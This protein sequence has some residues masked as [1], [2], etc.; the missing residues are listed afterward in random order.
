MDEETVLEVVNLLLE[1]LGNVTLAEAKT[2]LE[3]EANAQSLKDEAE[4]R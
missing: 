1:R 2:W 4:G 3:V